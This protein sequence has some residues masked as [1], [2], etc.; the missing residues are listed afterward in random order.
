LATVYGSVR[1]NNG[2]ISVDSKP[3]NGTTF[4]IYFP[5][6]EEGSASPP[7]EEQPKTRS[8]ATETVLV[9]EDE[10]A[11]RRTIRVCLETLG[12]TILEADRPEDAL[13]LVAKH[14]GEI[15]LLVTDVVLPDMNGRD[16]AERLLKQHP[17]LKCLFI[18]GFTAD[19]IARHGVLRVG[20]NFLA[21][22]FSRGELTR[23]V[24]EMLEG[25]PCR[26]TSTS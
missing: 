7:S 17:N 20:V 24:R 5:R 11:L 9:V 22:P 1:Q 26:T 18:S 2:F 21:R 4:R 14:R 23:K 13:H 19:G 12:Y 10:P 8:G 25:Q 16:L 15:E 6:V 3:G